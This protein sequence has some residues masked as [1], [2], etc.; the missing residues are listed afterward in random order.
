MSI[1]NQMEQ[2]GDLVHKLLLEDEKYRDSDR[3]LC[4]KIWSIELC[5][6]IEGTRRLSAFDF[7]C[8]YSK[9]NAQSKLTST[10]SIERVR[11]KLQ[12]EFPELRGKSYK[13]KKSK[14]NEVKSYL[15][16]PVDY[17]E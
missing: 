11:R 17:D 3:K 4:C 12:E 10:A 15:G 9:P 7:F 6:S 14:E 2:V 16:Y 13:G 8:E 1:T 5:G